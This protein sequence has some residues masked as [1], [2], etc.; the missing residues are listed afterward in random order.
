VHLTD[1]NLYLTPRLQDKIVRYER[2]K[3]DSFISFPPTCGKL[4]SYYSKGALKEKR[5][6]KGC[7]TLAHSFLPY[8]L[9]GHGL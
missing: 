7:L 8:L 3:E 5:H 4:C 9:T 1:L 2:Y 6:L